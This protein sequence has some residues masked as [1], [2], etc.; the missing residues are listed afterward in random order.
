MKEDLIQKQIEAAV[1]FAN[2]MKEAVEIRRL[3]TSSGIAPPQQLGDFLGEKA[4]NGA[5]KLEMKMQFP[6][7][8]SPARPS[9]VPEG[10]LWIPLKEAAPATLTLMLLRDRTFAGTK[11]LIEEVVRLCPVVNPGSVYNIL[12]RFKTLIRKSDAGLSIIDPSKAPVRSDGA[13]WWVKDNFSTHELAAHRRIV[14]QHILKLYPGGLQ[15][16][17]LLEQLVASDL[18]RAPISKD[19]LKID[20]EVMCADGKVKRISNSKKW[21]I[22]DPK[23]SAN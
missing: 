10:W 8:E 20:M 12:A 3:Y 6:P 11:D 14:I 13:V 1:R 23:E 21:V 9:D 4:Q 19:L 16:M 22:S 2:W 18:C 15:N 5:A 17:Q 7:L